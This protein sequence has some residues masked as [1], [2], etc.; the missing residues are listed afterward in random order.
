M[1][2]VIMQPTFLPWAGYFHLMAEA[3]VFVFL[4]DVQLVKQ[5][6]QT[7]N[8]I[9]LNGQPHWI[10]VPIVHTSLRQNIFGTKLCAPQ[11][12]QD[13]LCRTLIQTYAH[14]P[15]GG[16]VNSLVTLLER[17]WG[18]LAA[19][20]IALIHRICDGMGWWTT[21]CH[22]A[23]ELNIH[24]PRTERLIKICEHFG[25]DEYLSPQGSRDYLEEDGFTTKTNI[26]LSFQDYTPAPYPQHGSDTFVSHLSM[27][28]V[29]ANLG[30]AG[31]SEYATHRTPVMENA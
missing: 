10:S 29:L 27:V 2:C 7:R 17:P 28:D 24:A 14:H 11:Y 20:N 21:K 12:W 18:S 16:A 5:S 15:Y 13:K 22:L 1:K 19:L 25:C 8:R 6:W 4:D 26:K 30:W 3:D 9:L 31:A 23:S